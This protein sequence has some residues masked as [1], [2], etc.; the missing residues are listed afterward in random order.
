MRDKLTPK[1]ELFCRE[2]IVDMNASR[3]ALAAGYGESS[4]HST[5][6]ENLQKPEIAQRLNELQAERAKRL[7]V[8]QDKVIR[9]LCRVA[10][11]NPRDVMEWGPAGLALKDSAELSEDA[12]A[13]VAEVRQS[14]SK[15]GGSM[16]LKTAD[17][18]RALE[19]LGRHLGMFTAEEDAAAA[20]AA[21]QIRIEVVRL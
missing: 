12:A 13:M 11:G 17:K 18:M 21:Q 1:Q 16:S 14:I 6:W 2:Y 20:R 7:Q 15:D 10:F 8:D 19:L 3:A 4:A 9:E 5:G